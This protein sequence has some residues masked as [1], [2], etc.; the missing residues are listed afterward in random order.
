MSRVLYEI[1]EETDTLRPYISWRA[2]LVN[3]V[4][5]FRSKE[6]AEEFVS[7][8]RKHREKELVKKS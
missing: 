4:G 6:A 2:Q 5:N 3:Y 1:W 8:I 7:S